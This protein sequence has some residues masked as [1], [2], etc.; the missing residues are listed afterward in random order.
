MLFIRVLNLTCRAF[1]SLSL[2]ALLL[3]MAA[4]VQAQQRPAM[5][6]TDSV[7]L[8]RPVAKDPCV[9]RFQGRYLLYYSLLDT[10]KQN[11]SIGIA[12]SADLTNWT[13]VGEM[14]PEKDYEGKGICAPG[15]LL[16]DG[17]VHLFYQ[18]YGNGPKDAICH[19]V[20][21]DGLHFERDAS[22]PIFRPT[23]AWTV[24]RAID[25]EVVAF[26]HRY[27]LF[28]ATR[29]PAYQVQMQGVAATQ[30][31]TTD[32]GRTTWRQLA[33][34]AV[35]RPRLPWEKQCVE[36][37]SCLR[38]GRWLYMFYAG[39]YNNEPQQI[40]VARSRDGVR[41]QRLADTPLL[42]NGVP[43]TWNASESGHPAIFRDEDGRTYLFYQGN[44][45]HGRTWHLSKVEVKW[46][47]G[48]PYVAP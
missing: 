46:K 1:F 10:E 22:N 42:R 9:V 37:A 13:K 8:G 3:A 45:D 33:D 6:Y 19:A 43:G 21:P 31:L 20:A 7:G 17:R 41:W 11:W 44:N 30:D 39:A 29:D 25:A 48:A 14:R 23:G 27:L 5:Y 18:T 34:S 12:A 24:G 15:V 40:G 26:D 38:R 32:F 47:H 35:L 36:G 2:G 16:K 28:F 4:P